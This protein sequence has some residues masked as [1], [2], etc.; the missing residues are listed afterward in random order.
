MKQITVR[1]P[2]KGIAVGKT[3]TQ[4]ATSGFTGTACAD[5]TKALEAALGTVTEDL[6]TQEMYDVEPPQEHLTDG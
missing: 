6:P 2:L 1:V 4:I 5:A 3:T